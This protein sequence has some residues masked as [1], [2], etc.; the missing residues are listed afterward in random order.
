MSEISRNLVDESK[1]MRWRARRLN[2]NRWL[3]TYAPVIGVLLLVLL[4]IYY[5]F[6]A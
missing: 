3:R 1:E 6:L 2:I 5:K 4:V